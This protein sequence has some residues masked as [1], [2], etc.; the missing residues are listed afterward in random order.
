MK[1]DA[2][3][4]YDLVIKRAL[5]Q[6]LC[7]QLQDQNWNQATLPVSKGGLGLRPAMKV[8]ISGYISSVKASTRITLT[9]LPEPCRDLHDYSN[10]AITEWKLRSGQTDEPQNQSFQSE[11]DKPM[12]LKRY[13]DLLLSMTSKVDKARLLQYLQNVPQNG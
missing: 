5:T 6:I 4:R 3:Q 10:L 2:L 11:W 1:E 13:T 8:A 7:I 9:L 12:Y